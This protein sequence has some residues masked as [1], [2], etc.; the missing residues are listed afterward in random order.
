MLLCIS[1]Q[2]CTSCNNIFFPSFQAGGS[3]KLVPTMT[4]SF[5]IRRLVYGFLLL[6]CLYIMF[7]IVRLQRGGGYF[8]DVDRTSRL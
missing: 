5:H 1:A 7:Q 6:G 2:G 4:F 8:D 3:A